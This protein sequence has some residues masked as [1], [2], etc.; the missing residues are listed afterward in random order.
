MKKKKQNKKKTGILAHCA[1]AG[2]SVRDEL[3]SK[4]QLEGYVFGITSNP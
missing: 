4:Q 2:F 1:L 3:R